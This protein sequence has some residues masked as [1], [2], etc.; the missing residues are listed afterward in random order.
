MRIGP[1]DMI[2]RQCGFWTV[3][4]RAP[5]LTSSR[6]N[7]ARWHVRCACGSEAIRNGKALRK[8]SSKHCKKCQIRQSLLLRKSVK[9]TDDMVSKTIEMRAAGKSWEKVEKFIGWSH[10][11]IKRNLDE[12]GC[13]IR[14]LVEM[15]PK[16]S[17]SRLQ[18]LRLLLTTMTEV[19]AA[20]H[21]G[22][23]LAS[24][25]YA[26]KKYGM[27]RQHAGRPSKCQDQ[28]PKA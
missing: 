8:G 9:I 12:R 27:Q 1:I 20:Q 10:P 13:D 5:D 2:G 26:L 19:E 14:P 17:E 7:G 28:I 22:I 4:G 6:A 18:K 23:G 16:W 21:L 15:K 25:R 11:V 24:V 3:T